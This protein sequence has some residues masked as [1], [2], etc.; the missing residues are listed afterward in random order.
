MT[1]FEPML[2][3]TVDDVTSLRYPLL[4]SPKLDGI[5]AT[6]QGGV[7]LSR[8]LKPIRNA[9][10]QALFGR[11]EYEGLDGELIVGPP[12][13]PDCFLRTSSGVMSA[14]IAKAEKTATP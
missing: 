4:A 2:S 12:H 10:T 8:N 13:A 6:V 11:K 3:G 1:T 5:R 14:A 7:V 9:H